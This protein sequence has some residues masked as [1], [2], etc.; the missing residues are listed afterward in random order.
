MLVM[1]DPREITLKCSTLEGG[2]KALG[3]I[4]DRE[5]RTICAWGRGNNVPHPTKVLHMKDRIIKGKG[6]VEVTKKMAES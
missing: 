4:V 5:P 6:G 3:K 2:P 1:E